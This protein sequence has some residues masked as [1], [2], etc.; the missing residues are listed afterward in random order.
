M[1]ITPRMVFSKH[2]SD[3]ACQKEGA[4][5]GVRVMT[6]SLGKLKNLTP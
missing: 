4:M 1:C 2:K 3:F 6:F 5:Q